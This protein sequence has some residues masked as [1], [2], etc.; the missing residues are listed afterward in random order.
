VPGADSQRTG[1]HG[2]TITRALAAAA[3]TAS[4]QGGIAVVCFSA[5]RQHAQTSLSI[6]CSE[7]AVEA[8]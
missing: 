1:D 7:I 6:R 8:T 4:A 5:D 2:A 3:A